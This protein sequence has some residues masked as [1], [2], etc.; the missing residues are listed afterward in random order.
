MMEMDDEKIS[1]RISREELQMLD[2]YLEKH[3]E[4]G[5]RSHFIKNAIRS[6]LDRD[7]QI[8]KDEV[9]E[10]PDGVF[11]ELPPLLKASVDALGGMM[12][13]SPEEYIRAL[14]VR[15][16]DA[17]GQKAKDIADRAIFVA[18]SGIRP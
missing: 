2:S 16:I 7:A 14:I 11:V 9:E 5:S 8:G 12:Y 4:E 3:P 13:R 18:T 6:R 15:A 17:D 10:K 1:L